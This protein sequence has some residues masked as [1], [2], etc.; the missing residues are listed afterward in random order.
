[1]RLGRIM[2]VDLYLNTF[3]LALLGLFFVAGIL[4]KGL[5]AFAVV[6]LHEL[7]HVACARYLGVLVT[8][9]ELL[10]FGGVTRMGSELVLDPVKEVYVAA[11][12]PLCNVIMVLLGLAMKNY[13]LWH[14]ELGPF[15]LQCNLLIA[16]FNLLP[17]L[18]LDGGR[19]YRASLAGRM[20][21]K[22]ATY[23][24]ATL[25]QVFAVAVVLLGSL[26]LFLGFTGL[27]ILFTGLFLFF[28]ATRERG[29]A[30][31]LF[32]GQLAG[33]KGEILRVG[34]LPVQSL[35][36]LEDVPLGKIVKPFLPQKFHLVLVLD[37]QWQYKG[38]L[39]EAQIIDGL[40]SHGVDLPVGRLPLHPL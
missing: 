30:P 29:M 7:A 4:G 20:S 1:M 37:R 17:A 16:A 13:G 31:Y 28:A 10:P 19:V 21:I 8:E 25:G 26:G 5:V 6:L 34:V 35:I 14:D 38:F 27:D 3:F 9:V 32:M 40:L 36:A 33:K 39:T 2:G 24:A 23:R 22:E 15:F 11:A 18:P 12:G